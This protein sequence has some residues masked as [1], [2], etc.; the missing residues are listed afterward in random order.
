[1]K[2]T[3]GLLRTT[4]KYAPPVNLPCYSKRYSK[5]FLYQAHDAPVSKVSWAHPQF[6]SIIA[7]SS[8]DRTVKIWEQTSTSPS[9][10]QQSS[11]TNGSQNQ[12]GSGPPSSRW[13]DRVVLPEAKGTVRAVEFAPHHF[14]LKLVRRLQSWWADIS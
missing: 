5:H 10:A 12:S 13:T 9:D 11:S 1:M 14:G 4:G 2:T 3:V 7:S 8:F 6:G